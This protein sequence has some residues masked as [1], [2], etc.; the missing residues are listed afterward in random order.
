MKSGRWFY[1]IYIAGVP[2]YT[3]SGYTQGGNT[4]M[5][6]YWWSQVIQLPFGGEMPPIRLVRVS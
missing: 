2:N 1:T 5:K 3:T 4:A 6:G